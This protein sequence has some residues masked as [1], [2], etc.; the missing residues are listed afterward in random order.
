MKN[1][2]FRGFKVSFG[3]FTR[4]SLF[5]LVF[6]PLFSHLRGV[7]PRCSNREEGAAGGAP[8]AAGGRHGGAG[9][10][11]RCG[12]GKRLG[13]RRGPPAAGRNL[14]TCEREVLQCTMGDRRRS[15]ISSGK[16]SKLR[17]YLA[18]KEERRLSSLRRNLR[19]VSRSNVRAAAKGPIVS[20]AQLAHKLSD[21][22]AY[23]DFEVFVE[24]GCPV[25]LEEWNS[26]KSCCR[27]A[28]LRCKHPICLTCM[29]DWLNTRAA[30]ECPA[31]RAAISTELANA[32]RQA[33]SGEG[34]GK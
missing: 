9:P 29:T 16:R 30:A 28:V 14:A 6:L 17:L 20:N 25:C 13:S 10:V 21:P 18:Q 23:P 32:V 12:H 31:C 22:T 1:S 26:N 15:L 4:C 11:A 33:A 24:D 27:A 5:F 3:V 2:L 8:I 34:G 19:V 7:S